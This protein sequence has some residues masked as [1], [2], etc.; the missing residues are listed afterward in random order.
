MDK[1]NKE[2]TYPEDIEKRIVSTDVQSSMGS[3][4]KNSKNNETPAGKAP[5]SNNSQNDHINNTGDDALPKEQP[6]ADA[7]SG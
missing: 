3:G 5:S 7:A 4:I 2:N 6:D 1:D